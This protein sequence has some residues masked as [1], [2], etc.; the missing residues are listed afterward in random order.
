MF[1]VYV[2]FLIR[3]PAMEP[4]FFPPGFDFFPY[5]RCLLVL[6]YMT[7]FWAWPSLSSQLRCSHPQNTLQV[8][9][10][11]SLSVHN[12]LALATDT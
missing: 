12:E 2:S 3:F 6:Y 8:L 7:Q 10:S 11:T 5:T 4:V 9:A 1:P